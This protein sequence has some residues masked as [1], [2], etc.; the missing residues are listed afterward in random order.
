MHSLGAVVRASRREKGLTLRALAT[1]AEVSATY[2]HQI[3]R[4][5]RIPSDQVAARLAGLLSIDAD[6]LALLSGRVPADVLGVLRANPDLLG[7]LR[8]VGK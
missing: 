2:V 4:D 1:L 6:A 3:E 5:E 8:G 7:Q